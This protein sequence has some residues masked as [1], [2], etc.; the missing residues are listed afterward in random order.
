MDDLFDVVLYVAEDAIDRP[1][2]T[3]SLAA[4]ALEAPSLALTRRY[5]AQLCFSWL[6]SME[7]VQRRLSCLSGN[8]AGTLGGRPRKSRRLTMATPATLGST[9]TRRLSCD[10]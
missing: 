8:V 6:K 5:H 2:E 3:V 9:P 7:F 1:R 4:I 10:S